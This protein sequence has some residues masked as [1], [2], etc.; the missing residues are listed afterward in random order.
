[1]SKLDSAAVYGVSM[2]NELNAG[3]RCGTTVKVSAQ[4]T[5]ADEVALQ[6]LARGNDA[7]LWFWSIA[8]TGP[9]EYS[10]RPTGG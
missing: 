4:A 10:S 9:G 8:S 1:M 2:C 7:E 6:R 5:S 3:R